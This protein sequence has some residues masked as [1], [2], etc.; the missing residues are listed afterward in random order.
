MFSAMLVW[1][2]LGAAVPDFRD[3][4]GTTFWDNWLTSAESALFIVFDKAGENQAERAGF[5]PAVRCY[6]Y[7]D[8]ANRCDSTLNSSPSNDLEKNQ[9]PAVPSTVPLLPKE[10]QEL[11]KA[12]P[13]LPEPIRVSILALVRASKQCS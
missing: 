9:N 13:D 2:V 11:I 4:L 3:K 7:A 8:L 5:E 1:S 10:L 6:S 12:W